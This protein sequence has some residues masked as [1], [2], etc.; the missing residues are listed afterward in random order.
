MIDLY[1]K[2]GRLRERSSDVNDGGDHV[3]ENL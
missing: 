2:G 3:N 1:M